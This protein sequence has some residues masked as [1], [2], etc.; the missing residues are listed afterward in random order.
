MSNRE[1]IRSSL[2]R[3]RPGTAE[4]GVEYLAREAQQQAREEPAEGE[5]QNERVDSHGAEYSEFRARL[6]PHQ[7][8]GGTGRA[9]RCLRQAQYTYPD[10]P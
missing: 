10:S 7:L 8:G 1:V 4:L 6:Q 5:Q 3:P 2:S 9:R